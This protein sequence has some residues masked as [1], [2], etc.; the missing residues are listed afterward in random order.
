MEFCQSVSLIFKRSGGLARV[1]GDYHFEDKN[2]SVLPQTPISTPALFP[3]KQTIEAEICSVPPHIRG[4][5]RRPA[6]RV[7]NSVRPA[8]LVEDIPR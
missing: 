7:P 2:L 3:M 5:P 4:G 1:T 6:H 8:V